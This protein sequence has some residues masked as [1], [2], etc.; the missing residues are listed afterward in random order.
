MLDLEKAF[1]N[2]GLSDFIIHQFKKKNQEGPILGSSATLLHPKSTGTI[3]LTSRDI[4]DHP[5]INLAYFENDED[6]QTIIRGIREYRK[7]LRTKSFI[8]YE[9]EEVRFSLPDCDV[10]QY[11]TDEYWRCYVSY[12][13]T[14]MYHPIGTCSMGI[15]NDA[16]TVVHSNLKI[17]GMNGVRV[18]DASVM[19]KHISGHNNAVVVMIAE[20]ACDIIKAEYSNVN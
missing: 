6:L 15:S 11:D 3:K 18:V 5:Q 16:N 4:R 2:L 10:F 12:F 19:P 13:S 9:I 14:T 17:K 7:L 20:K 1:A 8:G